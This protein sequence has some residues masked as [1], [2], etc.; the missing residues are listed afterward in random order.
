[1]GDVIMRP[2]C[3]ICV[4]RTCANCF[5]KDVAVNRLWLD[6]HLPDGECRRCGAVRAAVTETPVR[7]TNRTKHQEHVD[8]YAAHLLVKPPKLIVRDPIQMALITDLLDTIQSDVSDWYF[9]RHRLNSGFYDDWRSSESAGAEKIKA[10]NEMTTI[11][12]RIESVVRR[13]TDTNPVAPDGFHVVGD[14]GADGDAVYLFCSR[15]PEADRE[16]WWMQGMPTNGL[17]LR[18]FPTMNWDDPPTT[19]TLRDLSAVA[20]EHDVEVHGG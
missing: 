15:C 1:M 14:N 2:E 11:M 12:L 3:P 17:F 5:F 16:D 6:K 19:C 13:W 10:E 4:T 7:H 20:R 18:K 8:G 9:A